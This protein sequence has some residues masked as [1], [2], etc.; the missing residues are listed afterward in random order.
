MTASGRNW[1]D[2]HGRRGGPGLASAARSPRPASRRAGRRRTEGAARRRRAGS[3]PTPRLP[4]GRRE[5]PGRLRRRRSSTARDPARGRPRDLAGRARGRRP[6]A[7]AGRPRDARRL[8]R[9]ARLL[10]A[11]ARSSTSPGW[12][13]PDGLGECRHL[14]SVLHDGP[15]TRGPAHRRCLDGCGRRTQ[16]DHHRVRA[17][18]ATPRRSTRP[19]PASTPL[20]FEG[21]VTAGGALMNT[22]DVENF[23]GFPDGVM[24]PDLM[25]HLR[26]Q[27]ER[28][29]AELVTDDVTEVDLAGDVEGR[30]T[31]AASCTARRRDP[32]HRLG[33][34][35]ARPAA[36]RS[37][38]SGHGVSWC[39]T[40]DGFFF[41]DQDIVVVGGGDSAMEE[42]T[43]LTRFARKVTV[44]HRRDTLRASKVM[45]ER[46]FANAKIEFVWDSEIVEI[47]G[48]DRV[49]GVRVRN[50]ETGEERTLDVT[51]LFVAIGHDPRSELVKG[52]LDLRRRGLRP[53]RRTRRRRPTCRRVRLRRRGRPHLPPGDHRRRHRL[54]R[55]ARRR[56]LPAARE[57]ARRT[58]TPR[59][60][61]QASPST[62]ATAGTVGSA[63]RRT[64]TCLPH[65]GD[66]R[67][68]HRTRGHPV[69]RP[70]RPSPTT[71]FAQDVLQQR[72]ARA[73]GLLGR[74]VRSVPQGRP[75]P[76]GDRRRA[77]RQ[78][79]RS[80]SSTSTRTRRPRRTTA[81]SRSRR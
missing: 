29:G 45:Q 27:A 46:A 80:S 52:Q 9:R 14:P 6:A 36:A 4:A 77:R 69:G 40:C 24:G 16:R 26:E 65:A 55:G 67:R 38:L 30:P 21:S 18:R 81:S 2:G 11:D 8:G 75:D 25:D 56:A 1:T 50:R 68:M 54:R 39:A 64:A 3:S 7:D 15:H 60:S 37:E 35:R 72:Q 76:R 34:P 17:R 5:A 44:V 22:T 41:R 73:R 51:G 49:A 48:D 62:R 63:W 61:T 70:P 12:R 32:R 13:A 28:F 31:A 20:V 10:T 43:F 79:R 53:G 19:G 42:A 58:A 59:S 78:D 47:L 66:R 57:D 33:V 71:T 23:P 74:V